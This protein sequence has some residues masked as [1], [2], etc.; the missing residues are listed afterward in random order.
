L[1]HVERLVPAGDVRRATAEFLRI[2]VG[3]RSV[4]VVADD[5]GRPGGRHWDQSTIPATP[6]MSK[7]MKA[8][9]GKA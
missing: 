9:I 4:R 3:H 2:E 6:S 8:L 7:E 5:L 1:H